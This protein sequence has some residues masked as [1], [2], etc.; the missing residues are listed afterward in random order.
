MRADFPPHKLTL[1]LLQL[2]KE[3]PETGIINL[4]LSSDSTCTNQLHSATVGYETLHLEKVVGNASAAAVQPPKPP[5]QCLFPDWLQGK[6][7]GLTIEGGE[8][9]YRDEKNFVTYRGACASAGSADRFVVEL[10]TD[11]GE[12]KNYCALFQQRDAN[13]MEF[14]LGKKGLE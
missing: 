7:E 11:C 12:R 10:E 9:V 4:A 8:M 14:Q 5:V 13:V 2:Y 6:W 1:F 3:D